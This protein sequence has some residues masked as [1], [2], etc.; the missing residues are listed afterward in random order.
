MSISKHSLPKRIISLLLAAAIMIGF[1]P[2]IDID[3]TAFAATIDGVELNDT[4]PKSGDNW[5]WDNTTQ[6]LSLYNAKFYNNATSS[7]AIKYTGTNTLKINQIGYNLIE[8]G[9]IQ[10][11]NGSIEVVGS[12]ILDISHT[13]YAMFD[14]KTLK[15]TNGYVRSDNATTLN[16][17]DSNKTTVSNCVLDIPQAEILAYA[18][19]DRAGFIME[20]GYVNCNEL[21]PRYNSSHFLAAEIKSGYLKVGTI[22]GENNS[23]N[24]AYIKLGKAVVKA[25]TLGANA[26]FCQERNSTDETVLA[27]STLIYTNDLSGEYKSEQSGDFFWNAAKVSSTNGEEIYHQDHN[28]THAR[29]FQSDQTFSSLSTL[30]AGDTI[31]CNGDLTIETADTIP[32]GVTLYCSGKLS[33]SGT[34]NGCLIGKTIN[35]G[36]NATVGSTGRIYGES[37]TLNGNATIDNGGAVTVYNSSDVSCLNFYNKSL[38]VNGDFSVKSNETVFNNTEEDIT[39]GTTGQLAAVGNVTADGDGFET[40]SVYNAIT[41]STSRTVY[42][43]DS[44][45]DKMDCQKYENPNTVY[46]GKE[47][48]PQ[49]ITLDSDQIICEKAYGD[50]ANFNF[51]CSHSINLN[52]AVVTITTGGSGGADVTSKFKITKS[53]NGANEIV[54]TLS[55]NEDIDAQNYNVTVKVG[56]LTATTTLTAKY[57]D[58]TLDFTKTNSGAW[59][60]FGAF[61]GTSAESKATNNMWAWYP[62]GAEGY[63]GKVLVLNNLSIKTT[64]ANAIIVPADTTIVVKGGNKIQSKNTAIKCKGKADIIG[65]DYTTSKLTVKSDKPIHE[66]FAAIQSDTGSVT[67]NNFSQLDV[68]MGAAT[69]SPWWVGE[70]ATTDPKSYGIYGSQVYVVNVE[71]NITA[72]DADESAAIAANGLVCILNNCDLTLK[73]NNYALKGNGNLRLSTVE[74][75]NNAYYPQGTSIDAA[76]YNAQITQN[77]NV[78]PCIEIYT[79]NSTTA[80]KVKTAAKLNDVDIYVTGINNGA[81][82][83][84]GTTLSNPTLNTN[85]PSSGYYTAKAAA[86]SSA[87]ITFEAQSG[88]YISAVEVG[89]SNALGKLFNV[90]K[91]SQNRIIK[92]DYRITEVSNH[93][94]IAVTFVNGN[95]H[96]LTVNSPNGTVNLNPDAQSVSGNVY[97]YNSSQNITADVTPNTGYKVTSVTLESNVL[98]PVNGTYTIGTLSANSTLTVAYELIKYSVNLPTTIPNGT[99]SNNYNGSLSEVPYGTQIEFTATPNSGYKLSNVK[100]NG[101]TIPTNGSTFTVTVTGATRIEVT[102]TETNPSGGG[103]GG[104]GGNHH[105]TPITTRLPALD[106]TGYNYTRM[107]EVLAAYKTGSTA[108]IETNGNYNVPEAVIKAIANGKLKVTLVMSSTVSRYIDGADIETAKSV[109][110]DVRV[111]YSLDTDELSGNE[112]MQLILFNFDVPSDLI[113]DLNA[114][115]AGLFANL[116]KYTNGKFEFAECAKIGKDG[117]AVFEN[118]NTSGTYAIMLSENSAKP[119]DVNNDGKL[120]AAD[121]AA[122]LRY[123]VKLDGNYTNLP[124][125]DLDS[126]RKINARDALLILKRVVG[127]I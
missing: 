17:S 61:G 63:T 23:N 87:K 40:S 56:E 5:V 20:S 118:Y 115:N 47:F 28:T 74:T 54:I 125:A 3:L 50:S 31:V 120:N 112:A 103:N 25:G 27:D 127:L 1:V 4:T 49:L 38:T 19:D 18:Q 55:L 69:E 9:Y 57:F 8:N 78:D 53:A 96:T 101:Q 26:A 116:Y 11:E 30:S 62:N 41:G 102:F 91:D 16:K 99:L 67:I 100:V 97:T 93:M 21:T 95:T 70:S 123:V 85:N 75:L 37:L 10:A 35:L 36:D 65:D 42:A 92:A 104:S 48:A 89:G 114:K 13:N 126:N 14:T 15:I 83:F 73:A 76:W 34:I 71:G 46:I 39:V 60:F 98:T 80:T 45:G 111:T 32:E 110:A 79:A 66:N 86:Y 33:C 72:D 88:Y 12:G 44:Y 58:Q 84:N 117:K 7:Y 24:Y 90:E 52:A 108:T 22:N 77:P 6:T 2:L 64:A 105:N 124:M 68:S 106:G 29:Y 113:I 43:S 109:D 82:K 81:V 94:H 119:G 107:A 59:E 121:A 122:V 51:I